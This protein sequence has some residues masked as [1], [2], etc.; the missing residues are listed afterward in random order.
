LLIDGQSYFFCTGYWS[1]SIVLSRQSLLRGSEPHKNR[2]KKAGL[3][4]PAF[5][6]ALQG[7]NLRHPACKADALPAELS[8]LDFIGH[9]ARFET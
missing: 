4:K 8:A 7:S 2:N 3:K 1:Q 6:W 5:L 9:A